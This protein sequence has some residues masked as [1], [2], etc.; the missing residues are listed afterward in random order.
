MVGELL[1]LFRSGSGHPLSSGSGNGGM[2]GGA[3]RVQAQEQG[4]APRLWVLS[5]M[6]VLALK[7]LLE[8][9]CLLRTV[10]LLGIMLVWPGLKVTE[11]GILI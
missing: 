4:W 10:T 11:T 5:V 3:G 7:F 1:Q 2:V 6:L 9:N 8:G